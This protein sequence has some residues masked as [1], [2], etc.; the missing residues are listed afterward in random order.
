MRKKSSLEIVLKG[1]VPFE[2]PAICPEQPH[3]ARRALCYD[4]GFVRVPLDLEVRKR[5]VSMVSAIK[6]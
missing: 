5:F 4:T 6:P 2:P 1:G 3:E